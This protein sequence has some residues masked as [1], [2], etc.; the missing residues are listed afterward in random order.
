MNILKT[1]ISL[2]KWKIH[3]NV[4]LQIIQCYY[5]HGYTF[6]SVAIIS[7]SSWAHEIYEIYIHDIY[8]MTYIPSYMYVYIWGNLSVCVCVC[9]CVFIRV[10]HIS[11]RKFLIQFIIKLKTRGIILYNVSSLPNLLF[12]IRNFLLNY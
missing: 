2:L 12:A 3:W 11:V 1:E 7:I 5:L 6:L 10:Y 9:V 4:M 8:L